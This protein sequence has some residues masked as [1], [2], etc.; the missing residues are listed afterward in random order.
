MGGFK[1]ISSRFQFVNGL[2]QH[3]PDMGELKAIKNAN[4]LS[5]ALKKGHEANGNTN[6]N[7]NVNAN[8]C[9]LLLFVIG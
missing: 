6:G 3:S 5:V 1:G 7:T 9:N 8:V 4:H 2:H